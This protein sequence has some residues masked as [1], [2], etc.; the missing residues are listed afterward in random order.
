M[1]MAM[2]DTTIAACGI[3]AAF[4]IGINY[5]IPI[6]HAAGPPIEVKSAADLHAMIEAF[7]AQVSEQSEHIAADGI[8]LSRTKAEI[9]RLNDE[10]TKAKAP[11][12]PAP[13][14]SSSPGS[15]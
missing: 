12:A 10:L 15:N 2:K 7:K 9:A 5:W 1:K 11:P 8:Q 4:T 14:S 6:S 13:T 3:F